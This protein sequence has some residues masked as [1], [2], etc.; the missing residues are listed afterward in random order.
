MDFPSDERQW[1]LRRLTVLGP[2]AAGGLLTLYGRSRRHFMPRTL[3]TFGGLGL[4]LSRFVMPR[5]ATGLTESMLIPRSAQATVT[6]AKPR[7]EVYSQWRAL[8]P[9]SIL[10][11]VIEVVNEGEAKSTWH[12]KGPLGSV[13]DWDAEITMEIPNEVISWRSTG[14]A[15]V[16]QVGIIRFVDA[17]GGGCEI[18]VDCSYRLPLGIVGDTVATL[19]ASSPNAMIKDALRA[20]KARMEAGDVPVSRKS[21]KANHREEP[22][23]SDKFAQSEMAPP[24]SGTPMPQ[25]MSEGTDD[26]VEDASAD[27]FPASD[28]PGYTR[29][30]ERA[31]EQ[32][33][34]GTSPQREGHSSSIDGLAPGTGV[35]SPTARPPEVVDDMHSEG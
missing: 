12:V 2:V 3:L 14:H 31:T 17:P 35:G 9:L 25:Y 10:P 28:P 5:S 13:A 19:T 32:P 20:F 27:S 26:L 8:A 24:P 15:D 1:P 4:L 29:G 33:S 21:D 34:R 7:L 30:A 11:H 18:Q 16:P 22:K 23:E 6:I